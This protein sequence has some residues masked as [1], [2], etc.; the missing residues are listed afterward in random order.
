MYIKPDL[1]SFLAA[2]G[3]RLWCES[4]GYRDF[5]ERRLWE[6]KSKDHGYWWLSGVKIV[7]IFQ[8]KTCGIRIF[9]YHFVLNLIACFLFSPDYWTVLTE[10]DFI[11]LE[12]VLKGRYL[13]GLSYFTSQQ[14]VKIHRECEE[15]IECNATFSVLSPIVAWMDTTSSDW[16]QMLKLETIIASGVEMVILLYYLTVFEHW[17]ICSFISLWQF[18]VWIKLLRS[19]DSS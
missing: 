2:S 11:F 18:W 19:S 10:K 3:T 7:L 12:A 5:G 8:W 13:P 16:I 17:Q 9:N 1:S 4:K 15:L 14:V 6:E